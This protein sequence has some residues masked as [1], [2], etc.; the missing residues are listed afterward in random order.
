MSILKVDTV[1]NIAGVEQAR[2][3]QVQ[4]VN[5]AT[6]FTTTS[7]TPVDITDFEVD[8]TPTNEANKIL[9]IVSGVMGNG[10]TGGYPCE[11]KL[12]RVISGG[13]TSN[14]AMGTSA[15]DGTNN[16]TIFSILDTSWNTVPV[17][18]VFLD[19]PNTTNEVTY[20]LQI[21]AGGGNAVW[22]RRG[23]DTTYSAHSSTTVMEIRT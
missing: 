18:V 13:A 9:V 14:I 1:Q 12:V 3:V 17:N 4:T 10:S 8:I 20:K 15:S 21:E 5:K 6:G 19:S 2:L 22:G 11:C 16:Y 7:G 23:D